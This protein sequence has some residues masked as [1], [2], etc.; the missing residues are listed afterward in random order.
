MPLPG[1]CLCSVWML[2]HKALMP[3][4][5]PWWSAAAFAALHL[6]MLAVFLIRLC[7]KGWERLRWLNTFVVLPVLP[8]TMVLHNLQTTLVW[9]VKSKRTAILA[10]WH[11]HFYRLFPR[12]L[13]YSSFTSHSTLFLWTRDNEMAQPNLILLHDWLLACQI[14]CWCVAN[15][16]GFQ[17]WRHAHTSSLLICSVEAVV[18]VAL[19][20]YQALQ[21][22]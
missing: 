11:F 3:S 20:E 12:S 17:I 22:R 19:A 13:R 18:A 4:T 6:Q 10:S 9:L 21:N 2:C 15:R 16:L 8:G 1:L 14:R 7:S 5:S